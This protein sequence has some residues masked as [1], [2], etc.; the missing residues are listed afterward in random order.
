MC[1]LCIICFL[2]NRVA[3]VATPYS[4]VVTVHV[5]MLGSCISDVCVLTIL[6]FSFHFQNIATSIT[7][8]N[9]PLS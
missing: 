3:D 7:D 4:I 9:L 6:I 1:N 5:S 8:D 2:A